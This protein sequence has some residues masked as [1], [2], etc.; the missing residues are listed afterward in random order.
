MHY[1]YDIFGS[2]VQQWLDDNRRIKGC[3]KRNVHWLR[4][5]N[6]LGKDF[7]QTNAM[8]FF[9]VNNMGLKQL[10]SMLISA[11][12]Q[13]RFINAVRLELKEYK[14]TQEHDACFQNTLKSMRRRLQTIDLL[15]KENLYLTEWFPYFEEYGWE[16]LKD[17]ENNGEHCE[18]LEYLLSDFDRWKKENSEKLQEHIEKMCK[19]KLVHE[20]HLQN[21]KDIKKQE[22]KERR[23]AKKIEDAEVK[24]IQKNNRKHIVRDKKMRR[25]FEKYYTGKINKMEAI[26]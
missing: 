2:Q 25:S 3:T 22:S 14:V 24:E 20:Q 10:H 21:I 6:E 1:N 9:M 8:L 7:A 16:N 5:Y 23:E 15:I 4:E 17:F 19:R 26:R 11:G 13:R 18:Q 12:K